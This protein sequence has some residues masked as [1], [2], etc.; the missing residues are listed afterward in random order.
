LGITTR[1]DVFAAFGQ[2]ALAVEEDRAVPDAGTAALDLIN[3]LEAAISIAP[4]AD[5]AKLYHQAF[6]DLAALERRH[7]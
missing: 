1:E 6:I 5:H 7:E 2:V 3:K 4:K